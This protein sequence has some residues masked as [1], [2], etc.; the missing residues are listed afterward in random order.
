M[1]KELIKSI[2]YLHEIKVNLWRKLRVSREEKRANIRFA[3]KTD[4]GHLIEYEKED[5]SS[6]RK[7]GVISI[8]EVKLPLKSRDELPQILRAL[9]YI[10]VTPDFNPKPKI[11][12]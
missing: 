7:L 9:Q 3:N 5:W 10:Y 12:F 8:S 11:V 2:E 1:K 4:K 6:K